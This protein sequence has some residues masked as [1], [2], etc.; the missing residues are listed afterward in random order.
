[1]VVS[2]VIDTGL[3]LAAV[4][5]ALSVVVSNINEQ[6]ATLLKWR[7][8]NLYSGVLNLL[9]GSR[10]LTQAL[11]QHPLIAS[12]QCD[13][14]GKVNPKEDYRPSYIGA[15]DFSLALWQS[16]ASATPQPAAAGAP[17]TPNGTAVTYALS[18]AAAGP[19]IAMDALQNQVKL[20]P[21][22]HLRATLFALLGQAQGDYQRLLAVTDAWFNRQMDRVSGWY[23][24]RA[25]YAVMV[26]S[27]VLVVFLGVDTVRITTR[28]YADDAL[29]SVFAPK[30]ADTIKSS[31]SNASSSL[32]TEQQQQNLLNALDDPSFVGTLVSGPVFLDGSGA[33]AKTNPWP[34]LI[35]LLGIIITMVA[36]SLG[37]PF[38]FDALQFF[39][40]SRLAGPKPSTSTSSQSQAQ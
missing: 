20:L 15:R 36:L 16:V 11:F 10:D 19:S 28:L 12:A 5:F 22:E 35:H 14:D 23:R 27:V 37:A 32:P 8:A 17:A 24:R 7:G 25:Q 34:L 31:G 26:I 18:A 1:M 6:I 39:A 40:N 21:S 9:S 30:V 2:R 4:Y 13:P 29:R 33:T 3:I 38:W